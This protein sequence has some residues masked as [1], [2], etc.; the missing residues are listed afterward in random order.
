MPRGSAPGERRGGRTAGTPNRATAEVADKL[1]ALG[2]D[3]I[4]AMVAIATDPAA[5]LTIRG[6][7]ASELAA[8]LHPKKRAIDL[9]AET[10][11][12]GLTV[13]I[14]RFGDDEP[15][16]APAGNGTCEPVDAAS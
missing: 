12:P 10:G 14:R 1:A 16:G 2:F 3:P 9:T 11:S 7:M 5:D 13:V 4:A 15:Q 8:Y 6:R